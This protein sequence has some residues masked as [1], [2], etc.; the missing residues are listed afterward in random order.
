M[1]LKHSALGTNT[2]FYYSSSCT[3]EASCL[4]PQL[5]YEWSDKFKNWFSFVA[6]L[7]RPG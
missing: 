6:H 3:V 5:V 2:A 1:A 4:S 7:H